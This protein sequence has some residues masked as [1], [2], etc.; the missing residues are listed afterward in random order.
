MNRPDGGPQPRHAIEAEGASWTDAGRQ[1]VS[2]AFR[3]VQEDDERLTLERQ[4]ND[5]SGRVGNIRRVEFVRS[6]VADAIEPYEHGDLD[7]ATVRY[8]PK[9]ADLVPTVRDDAQLGPAA[10]SGYFG[11]DHAD[12]LTSN[13]DFRRALAH[14][15]DRDALERVVPGQRGGRDRRRRASRAPR[16]HAGHRPPVRS[17]RGSS[18]PRGERHLGE[19]RHDRRYRDV[20]RDVPPGAWR[21]RG[22]T[23]SDSTCAWS[24]GRSNE[25]SRSRTSARSRPSCSPVGCPATPIP[26]TSCDCSSSRTARR[27]RAGSPIR[28]STS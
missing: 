15:V 25:H 22:A 28:R 11:F 6:S 16:A 13:V 27:T 3:V 17:G 20:G 5:I 2:G 23:S 21:T 8:T 24:R 1:V 10:W 14:A 9:L 26:S 4:P 7:I 12:P 18:L 19:E